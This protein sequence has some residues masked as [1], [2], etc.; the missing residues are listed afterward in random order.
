M[1]NKLNMLTSA[2]SHKFNLGNTG[3]CPYKY[4]LEISLSKEIGSNKQIA[5][6]SVTLVA[7]CILRLNP[8]GGGG[9][10]I[11]EEYWP[12]PEIKEQDSIIIFKHHL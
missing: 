11:T 9:R 1:T 4:P 7:E 8:E 12:S 10:T 2:R 3:S 6:K 5:K